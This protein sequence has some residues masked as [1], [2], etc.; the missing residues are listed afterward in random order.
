MRRE[1]AAFSRDDFPEW[2]WLSNLF[3]RAAHNLVLSEQLQAA[4]D[5]LDQELRVVE[6]IQR[7]LLPGQ[8]PRILSLDLAA[9]YQPSRRASGDYYDFFPLPDGKW[10]IL[11]ADVSGH[12]TPAAVLMAITHS[13]A[14]TYAG[15]PAPPG[16]LLDHINRNLAERYTAR[17]GAFV[18]AFHAVYDPRTATLHID[19][20]FVHPGQ[21]LDVRHAGDRIRL[22][23]YP[24]LVSMLASAQLRPVAVFGDAVAPAVAFDEQSLW[25]VVVAAKQGE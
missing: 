17:T 6:E 12:G 21:A 11:I 4:Y 16:L 5:K 22:Y 14:H 7:T 9:Y 24:E 2:V 3:G 8:L 20:R 25:Q 19:Y 13:L 18:T 1:P 10:G 23:G 15:P